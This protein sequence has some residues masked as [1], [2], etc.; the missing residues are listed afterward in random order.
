MHPNFRW[1]HCPFGVSS[2]AVDGSLILTSS[3]TWWHFAATTDLWSIET[4]E[5]IQTISGG[6]INCLQ[7]ALFTGSGALVLTSS[8]NCDAAKLWNVES[9]VCIQTFA[10][11]NLDYVSS[12]FFSGDRTLLLTTSHDRTAK[13]W[14]TET[15]ACIQTFAGHT[16]DVQS[17]VWSPPGFHVTAGVDVLR[18]V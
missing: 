15:G 18:E 9:G 14:S 13:L 2:I 3:V 6:H 10:H 17:A 4:G 5:C 8:E 12:A 16:S 7:S 11:T 1:P